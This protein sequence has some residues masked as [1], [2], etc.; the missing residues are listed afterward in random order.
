MFFKV[1]N[2]LEDQDKWFGGVR[3]FNFIFDKISLYSDYSYKTMHKEETLIIIVPWLESDPHCTTYIQICP[4]WCKTADK[5]S[6][7]FF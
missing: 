3:I 6:G 7:I 1:S 4:E 2:A 5:D